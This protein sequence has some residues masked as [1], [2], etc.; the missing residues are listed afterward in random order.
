MPSLDGSLGSLRLNAP[1]VG[2]AS[3][4][5]EGVPI[6][7]AASGYFLVG[8]DGGVFAFGNAEFIGSGVG[9][10]FGPA[11]GISVRDLAQDPLSPPYFAPVVATAKGERLAWGQH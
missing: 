6:F 3:T 10:G 2:I 4:S 8:A 11:I 5:Y 7:P 9:L 1:I